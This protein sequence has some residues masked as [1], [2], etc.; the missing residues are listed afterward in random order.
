ML[1]VNVVIVGGYLNSRTFILGLSLTHSQNDMNVRGWAKSPGMSKESVCES[2]MLGTVQT[3]LTN[4]A[5]SSLWCM[6]PLRL[7]NKGHRL[8]S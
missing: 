8:G 1:L 5:L 3:S 4:I 2:F 6:S 7:C